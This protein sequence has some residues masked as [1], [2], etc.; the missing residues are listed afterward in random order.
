[1]VTEGRSGGV[2]TWKDAF[3]HVKLINYN[4]SIT[5]IDISRPDWQSSKLS[6]IGNSIYSEPLHTGIVNVVY[7][8]ECK[9]LEVCS[10]YIYA[11]NQLHLVPPTTNVRTS[12]REHEE[13]RKITV[14]MRD[15]EG[16]LFL[17]SSYS[18][19]P[20]WIKEKSCIL[21]CFHRPYVVENDFFHDCGKCNQ[22]CI[23]HS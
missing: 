23:L 2:W 16:D 20:P 5:L 22:P 12:C 18:A 21:R 13:R 1:M 8:P 6:V 14:L 15:K 7:H 9:Y 4:S 19:N 11:F 17:L 3:D 10:Q